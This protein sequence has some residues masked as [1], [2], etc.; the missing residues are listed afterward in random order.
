[1]KN[2]KKK[3]HLIPRMRQN[4]IKRILKFNKMDK[5]FK[6]EILINKTLKQIIKILILK[7]IVKDLLALLLSQIKI[8]ITLIIT[9]LKIP[10]LKNLILLLIFGKD[11]KK[12]L[13]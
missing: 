2:K 5:F 3:V 9:K 8:K 1:M 6:K 10:K 12:T 11:T 13:C 7:K 4:R